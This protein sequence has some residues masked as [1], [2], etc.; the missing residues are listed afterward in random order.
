MNFGTSKEFQLN[1]SDNNIISLYNFHTYIKQK[2]NLILIPHKGQNVTVFY[3][4]EKDCKNVLDEILRRENIN[5]LRNNA[6]KEL[7]DLLDNY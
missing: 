5:T 3:E 7:D 6:L 1:D 2:N 4:D